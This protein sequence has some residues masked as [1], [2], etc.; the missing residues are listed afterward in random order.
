[1]VQQPQMERMTMSA[2]A[3]SIS[4][5]T[6]EDRLVKA[7]LIGISERGETAEDLMA[8]AVP[9]IDASIKVGTRHEAV[10]DMCGTGGAGFRT[11]NVSTLASV[12]A[13]SVGIPV[14][15]HGNRS[16]NG[17]CGSAD[18][19]EAMGF[20]I[21]IEKGRAESMLD[22]IGFTFLFAPSYH[23]AMRH[24]AP[25]R[26]EI[27]KR[28]IFNV[29]GPLLNPVSSTKRQMI[30]V[31]D[32]RTLDVVADSLSALGIERGLVIHGAPG[33][34]EVSTLGP[35]EVVEVFGGNKS[36]FQIDPRSLGIEAPSPKDVGELAPS[37]AAA[38]A[39]DIL[40]GN[41]PGRS[42]MVML[43]AACGLY[44]FGR[45]KTIESGVDI[46]SD[47]M[48]SGKASGQL[49]RII[50]SGENKDGKRK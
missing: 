18:L 45:A 40:D 14:A 5:G 23:P 35:T 22:E 48:R 44:A 38:M 36:K 32:V 7:A 49:G 1:M 10:L 28:T 20:D 39:M 30:G 9:F 16:S 43:N 47:A 12:V 25:I 11:F 29:L 33:M 37:E 24:V 21:R 6:A 50:S 4:M 41:V 13:S 3:R 46:A 27:G 26:K 17:K 31:P 2:L 34:D 15:K 8:F 19:M 42:D